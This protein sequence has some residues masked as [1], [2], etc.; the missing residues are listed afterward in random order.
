MAEVKYMDIAEFR[1]GGY[2]QEV[3]RRFLHPLGLALEVTVDDDGRERLSGVWDYREDPDGIRYAESM[4]LRPHAATIAAEWNLRS[5][6]REA[7][8]GYMIQP[9]AG[10]SP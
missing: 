7:E 5:S 10:E 8:L 1:S 2:L 4:D 9:A 6:T 3:N